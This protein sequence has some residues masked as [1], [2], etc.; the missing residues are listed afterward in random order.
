[1]MMAGGDFSDNHDL[2]SYPV[3]LSI[4]GSDSIGGAGI[5][6]DIKTCC[7]L[8]VYAMTAITGLT[9]Q[10]TMGVALVDATSSDM[11]RAQLDMIIADV[12]PDAVKIGML[13]TPEIIRIVAEWIRANELTNVVTDPVMV[14]TSNDSLTIEPSETALKEMLIPLS[15]VITPN[16][17]EAE[18]LLGCSIDSRDKRNEALD[19]LELGAKYVLLKGGHDA[20]PDH[21]VDILAG[22]ERR[23]K[24]YVTDKIST[25]NTHGTGCTLSSAIACGLAKGLNV[26]DA[27]TAAHDF[28]NKAIREGARYKFG[29]GHGPLCHLMKI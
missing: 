13:P 17:P 19:L 6:A 5:Q 7:A 25:Q 11:M 28:V 23:L 10:N 2:L 15:T 9:A 24:E 22:S 26:E 4:A 12:R 29:H 27:V 8:G 14:A 21:C 3:V 16:L 18:K 1:M 20:D